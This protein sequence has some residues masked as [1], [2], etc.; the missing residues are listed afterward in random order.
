[1]WRMDA[2]L[3]LSSCILRQRIFAVNGAATWNRPVTGPVGERLQAGTE[4]A[5]VLDC[6][7]HLDVFMILAP[8]LLT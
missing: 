4:D 2:I 6:R 3:F 8:N 7:R 1:M 5:P